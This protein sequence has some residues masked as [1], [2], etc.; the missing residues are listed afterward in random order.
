MLLFFPYYVHKSVF[1]DCISIPALQIGSSVLLVLIP[2]PPPGTE[3]VHPPSCTQVG[4]SCYL[5]RILLTCP[6]TYRRSKINVK[7]PFASIYL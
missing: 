5:F 6:I 2:F 1:C 4:Q 7:V 3:S